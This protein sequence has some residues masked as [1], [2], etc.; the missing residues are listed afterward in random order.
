VTSGRSAEAAPAVRV[1]VGVVGRVG[2]APHAHAL[3][4]HVDAV[5]GGCT[6]NVQAASPAVSVVRDQLGVDV[7]SPLVV[8]GRRHRDT[9]QL[10][11]RLCGC[12]DAEHGAKHHGK[13]CHGLGQAL[14]HERTLSSA[15]RVSH[16]LLYG[17]GKIRACM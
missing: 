1:A 5:V 2:V 10:G 3:L 13:G 4:V 14:H 16:R 8:A 12:L 6:A 11:G 17:S 9:A 7:R 15:V